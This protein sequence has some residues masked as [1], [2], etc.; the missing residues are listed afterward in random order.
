MSAEPIIL[1]E[2]NYRSV[3]SAEYLATTDRIVDFLLDPEIGLP[4]T[5]ETNRELVQDAD[6]SLTGLA[7]RMG[8]DRKGK[9]TAESRPRKRA[10]GPTRPR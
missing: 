10:A 5:D 1:P 2:L 9:F 8:I 3:E 6:D 4:L 7:A